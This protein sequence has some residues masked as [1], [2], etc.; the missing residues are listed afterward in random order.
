MES[1]EHKGNVT[2]CLLKV[3]V[4]Q[5]DRWCLLP[6]E[7]P[8]ISSDGYTFEHWQGRHVICGDPLGSD[9]LRLEVAS[10]GPEGF[11]ILETDD[12]LPQPNSVPTG[13]SS[14]CV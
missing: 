4:T 7:S 5:R 6:T 2:I 13:Y 14:F 8:F 12:S 9:A 11:I 10:A 1:S 3:E